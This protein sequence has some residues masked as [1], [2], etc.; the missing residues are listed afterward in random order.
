MK[1]DNDIRDILSFISEIN[2]DKTDNDIRD[3][4]F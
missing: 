2:T 1:L 4:M 3:F